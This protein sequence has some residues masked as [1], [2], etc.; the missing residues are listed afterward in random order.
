[1][2]SVV[3]KIPVVAIG[4][5]SRRTEACIV[6]RN[7]RR[8][9]GNCKEKISAQFLTLLADIADLS[10][11]LTPKKQKTLA[12]SRVSGESLAKGCF[13]SRVT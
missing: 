3:R 9:R 2:T 6:A 10:S 7:E 4:K 12:D 5:S 1:M 8:I 13:P 11:G